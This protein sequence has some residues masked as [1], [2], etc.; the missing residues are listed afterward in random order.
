MCRPRVLQPAASL[1]ERPSPSFGRCNTHGITHRMQGHK[2][3]IPYVAC[4]NREACAIQATFACQTHA[5]SRL[6]N[7]NGREMCR[8]VVRQAK[9]ATQ[10]AFW[11]VRR[12]D[13]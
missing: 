3:E 10:F 13:G 1:V 8:Q 4:E 11:L 9:A 2:S 12:W 6:I 7:L 5:G